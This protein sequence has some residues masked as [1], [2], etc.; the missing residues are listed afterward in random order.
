M[1]SMKRSMYVL[2]LVAAL[3]LTL[4]GAHAQAPAGAGWTGVN[5]PAD[6]IA[7][8]AAL[9]AEL[10]RLM[11]PV[12]TFAAGEGGDVDEVRAAA[13]TIAPLLLATPHLFP[14]TTNLYD[15]AAEQPATLALPAIWQSFPAFYS[16][17]G[18][19]AAA[20]TKMT[21]LTNAEELRAAGTALRAACDA[22]HTP[23]LRPYVASS[24]SESDLDFD[25]D[26]VLKK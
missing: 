2:A 21:G 22:C 13:T 4:A 24:V 7:A 1:H 26:S 6:V 20:A 9:M 15:P 14:P 23:Y 18:A 16:M 10:E 19:A 25:F 12:D 17:A 5:A 11:R 8:R 3:G